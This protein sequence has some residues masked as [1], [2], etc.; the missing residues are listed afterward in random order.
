MM[1][2]NPKF[3]KFSI[4]LPRL[5]QPFST[6]EEFSSPRFSLV[7]PPFIFKALT[8]A[9]KTTADGF[10]SA[11]LHLILRNFSAP[12]SAPKPASVTT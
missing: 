3:F 8:V 2:G 12:K 6:A 9:T 7:T 4:C 11:F 5:S 10:K 1:T